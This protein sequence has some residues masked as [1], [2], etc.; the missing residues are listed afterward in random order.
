MSTPPMIV[1][2]YCGPECIMYAGRVLSIPCAACKKLI[3]TAL[4]AK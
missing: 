2:P 3:A 1:C 4:E